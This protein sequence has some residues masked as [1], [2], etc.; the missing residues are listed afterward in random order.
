[1]CNI[2]NTFDTSG[3]LVVGDITRRL[4][5]TVIKLIDLFHSIMLLATAE[6]ECGTFRI[7]NHYSLEVDTCSQTNSYEFHFKIH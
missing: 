2:S 7:L 4:A 6:A 3:I 5:V 1:M